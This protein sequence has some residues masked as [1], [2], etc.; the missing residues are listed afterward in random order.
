VSLIR[1][2]VV[3]GVILVSLVGLG[4]VGLRFVPEWIPGGSWLAVRT[5]VGLITELVILLG[6]L[7]AGAATLTG[8]RR[9]GGVRARARGGLPGLDPRA[10][11]GGPRAR[12]T[13]ARAEA[14]RAGAAE[15]IVVWT[16][17]SRRS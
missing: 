3:T 13:D 4:W 2:L 11:G 10:A 16:S 9:W 5:G 15:A 17:S 14:E 1:W 6:A 8:L 12:G 7:L